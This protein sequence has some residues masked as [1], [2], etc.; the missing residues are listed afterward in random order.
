MIL[1]KGEAIYENLNT[2]FTNFGELLSNLKANN[3]TG[4]VLVS[5]W[6]YEGVFFLDSGNIINAIEEGENSRNI[7]QEAVVGLLNKAKQK[8]G[9]ISVYKLSP[10]LVTIL[11]GTGKSEIVYKELTSDFTNLEKLIDKLKFEQHTGYVEILTNDKL[12][13][14]IIFLQAGE[15]IKSI[16]LT[17]EKVTSNSEIPPQIYE[18]VGLNGAVY[19]VYKAG[20][21]I[22]SSDTFYSFD[23]SQVLDFWS[24]VIAAIENNFEPEQFDRLFRTV[25][26]NKA[27]D[28][29]FLDPFAEEFKYAKGK[30]TFKGNMSTDFSNGIAEALNDLIIQI[31]G[32]TIHDEIDK[33]KKSQS[34]VIEKFGLEDILNSILKKPI[35]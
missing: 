4:Y 23:M 15:P 2:S 29:P 28:Y 6:E 17:G 25:L 22:N 20:L 33:I 12:S 24:V 9:L 8:D 27:D 21:S 34:E 14:A 1:P 31:S 7:G 13:T 30:I 3:I 5:F 18:L 32:T 35:S 19:T 16:L 11:A 26:I 10:D